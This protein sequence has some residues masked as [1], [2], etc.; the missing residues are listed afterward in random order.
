[1][2]LKKCPRCGDRHVYIYK[3]VLRHG[4]RWFIQCRYCRFSAKRAHTRWGAERN[5]NKAT[6]IVDIYEQK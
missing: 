2:K 6:N 4:K 3:S 1:M 5:W